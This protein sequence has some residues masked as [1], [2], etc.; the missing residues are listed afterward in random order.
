MQKLL[1][2]IRNKLKVMAS[3]SYAWMGNWS[4]CVFPGRTRNN[5]CNSPTRDVEKLGEAFDGN[6]LAVKHSNRDHFFSGKNS[7]GTTFSNQGGFM[8]ASVLP[9]GLT[10]IPSQIFE[11]IVRTVA[12]VMASLHFIRA[13]ANES[14]KYETVNRKI[15]FP[16]LVLEPHICPEILV[17]R[18]FQD[19]RCSSKRSASGMIR[20]DASQIAD[21]IRGPVGYGFPDFGLCHNLS[22]F[23]HIIPN[24]ISSVKYEVN[25]TR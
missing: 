23:G 10:G 16:A 9:I 21:F 15:L 25:E 19:S 24:L 14:E 5:L 3:I 8:N 1:V 22:P 11:T 6:S 13:G 18:R 12:I 20:S 4:A 17:K 7:F 2:D